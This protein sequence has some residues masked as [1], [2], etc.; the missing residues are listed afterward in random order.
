MHTELTFDEATVPA[1]STREAEPEVKTRHYLAPVA[2]GVFSLA[3]MFAVSA[4]KNLPIRDPDARLVGSPL[5][6]ICLIVAVFIV[7]DVV[8]RAIRGVRAKQLT[9]REAVRRIFMERWWGRR[10]VIVVACILGF[11]ATY[12][13]YRNL[14]SFLPFVMPDLHDGALLN[15][16]QW[17]FF[18]AQPANVLHDLLGTGISAHVLSAAYVAFLSFVPISLGVTLIWSSRVAAGV[19]YVTALT[20]N[21]ILGA[22]SYYLIPSLGP[23]FV[24]PELFADLPPNDASKLGQTLLEHRAEVM[25]NPN[26]TDTVQSIAAFASLHMAVVFTAALIAQLLGVPRWVRIVLWAYLALTALATIY[27]GWHYLIDDVAGIAIGLIAVFGAASLTGFGHIPREL[28][29]R[30]TRRSAEAT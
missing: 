25:A 15:M 26:A 6:L 30:L 1:V 8:P 4:A 5:A 2:I 24:R 28:S 7:L 16:D 14:K 22:L 17:L 29:A 12:L 3:L 9:P 11:Y 19:W 27:F 13:S 21:W 20:I 10:G 23:M 18:G